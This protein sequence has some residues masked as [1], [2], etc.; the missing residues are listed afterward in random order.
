MKGFNTAHQGGVASCTPP[1]S[2]WLDFAARHNSMLKLLS[3]DFLQN[4]H[5]EIQT[6]SEEVFYRSTNYP[7]WRLVK[8]KDGTI[9]VYHR[10][11]LLGATQNATVYKGFCVNTQEECAIK[12]AIKESDSELEALKQTNNLYGVGHKNTKSTISDKKIKGSTYT[13]Y[14]PS[15]KV[16][17]IEKL[18]P[19]TT[20]NDIVACRK[21]NISEIISISLSLFKHLKVFHELNFLHRDIKPSNICVN[22]VSSQAYLIDYHLSAKVNKEHPCCSTSKLVGSLFTLAPEILKNFNTNSDYTYTRQSDLYSLAFSL[23]I[24]CM[25]QTENHYCILL[26]TDSK[27]YVSNQNI[28]TVPYWHQKH[29]NQYYNEHAA[30]SYFL[31]QYL[32]ILHKCLHEPPSERT[33]IDN[34]IKLLSELETEYLLAQSNAY[35]PNQILFLQSDFNQMRISNGLPTPPTQRQKSV[36]I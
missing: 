29:F 34:I 36:L 24:V 23:F 5:Q 35:T 25:G 26:D 2:I 1:L 10:E 9:A 19:P 21:F 20:L 28:K 17:L 18:L 13:I 4:K 32:N 27:V 31:N 7:K 30:Y 14:K 16:V 11:A 33:S 6:I 12:C 22:E 3:N 8:T 15:Q